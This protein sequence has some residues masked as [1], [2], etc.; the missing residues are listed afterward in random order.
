MSHQLVYTAVFSL[1]SVCYHTAHFVL[2]TCCHHH[3]APLHPATQATKQ[4]DGNPPNQPHITRLPVQTLAHSS[5]SHALQFQ[6]V[7]DAL[8]CAACQCC[9]CLCKPKPVQ[10]PLP[11]WTLDAPAAWFHNSCH[12]LFP[13]KSKLGQH[14]QQMAGYYT[15]SCTSQLRVAR[16]HKA[17]LTGCTLC[18]THAVLLVHWAQTCRRSASV[19]QS[20]AC[21][22]AGAVPS[23]QTLLQSQLPPNGRSCRLHSTAHMHASSLSCLDLVC[24]SP[25]FSTTRLQARPLLEARISSATPPNTPCA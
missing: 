2:G 20:C 23:A 15:H 4:S 14:P 12:A 11:S 22:A 10:S 17:A 16:T 13:I 5:K 6:Q 25:T 19:H 7:T 21:Q 9:L 18:V 8:S 1:Y 3:H 24:Q